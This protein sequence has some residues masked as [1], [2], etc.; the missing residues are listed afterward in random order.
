MREKL[1]NHKLSVKNALDV[2]QV[3]TCL[4]PIY[5]ET[6]KILLIL[7]RKK[8]GRFKSHNITNILDFL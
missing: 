5:N 2:L 1:H 8:L 6:R 7:K 4:K 3:K